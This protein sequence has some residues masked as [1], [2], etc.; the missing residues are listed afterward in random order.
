MDGWMG[1]DYFEEGGG[2]DLQKG[3]EEREREDCCSGLEGG[4]KK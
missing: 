3:F 1:R 2:V 4:G